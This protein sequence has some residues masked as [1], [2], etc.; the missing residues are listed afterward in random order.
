[1]YEVVFSKSFTKKAKR[2]FRKHPQM[3][4]RYEKSVRLLRQNP[5]HP[6][7]RL[8]KLTGTLRSYY[9]VSLS[10]E[11]R[12]LLDFIIEDKRIILLDIGDHDEVYRP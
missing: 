10:M 12:L 1:M 9:S 6:S 8:H 7:L 2:F 5:Y 11:Y 3:Q 4:V